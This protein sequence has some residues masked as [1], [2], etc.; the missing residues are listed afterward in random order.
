VKCSK[1][2]KST[3]EHNNDEYIGYSRGTKDC[4]RG[5][6]REK[7]G[8]H[9]NANRSPSPRGAKRPR[10]QPLSA[11]EESLEP[12]TSD[13]P[14]VAEAISLLANEGIS[15]LE[16]QESYTWIS[17]AQQIFLGKEWG[18]QLWT[19]DTLTSFVRRMLAME[20]SCAILEFLSM[21][22][23]IQFKCQVDR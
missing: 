15:D 9:G 23:K 4:T 21:L 7:N 14:L 6:A 17:Q 5:R 11:W 8:G 20:T 19:T 22:G 3:K 12:Y 2:R 1:K 10:G 18:S 13:H 16:S